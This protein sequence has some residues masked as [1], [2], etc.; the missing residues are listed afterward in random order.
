MPATR[1]LDAMLRR[2]LLL[3]AALIA[4]VSCP[5]TAQAQDDHA[6]RRQRMVE[7]IE[8]YAWHLE[9]EL[10]ARK[11][12]KRVLEAMGV[13]P[14]HLFVPE[15]RRREAYADRPVPI[16]HGQTISQP[17]IVAFM[18]HLLEVEP[19]DVVLELGTG[20]GYQAAVLAKLVKSVCSIEIIPDLGNTAAEVLGSLGLDNVRTRI[21][22]GYY[23]WPECGPFDAIV[24][25]AAAGHIPPPLVAQLKPGG[26]MII[27]VGSPYV[28]QQLVL[29]DKLA[30]GRV[31]T[32]QMLAVRFVPLVREAP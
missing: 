22:D 6:E 24:V 3:A 14:R 4:A 32:R 13:L 1:G 27:P 5:W 15:D 19:D 9:A 10:G 2:S 18:T 20:S 11:I 31:T 28:T 7:V 12:D 29:I 23:G 17:L 16:G 8:R 25:T 30:D 26:K 21:G